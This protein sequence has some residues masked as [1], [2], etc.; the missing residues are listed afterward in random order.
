MDHKNGV[1]MVE[2]APEMPA[3][4]KVSRELVTLLKC[5]LADAEAGKIVAGGVVVVIGPSNFAAF[6]AMGVYPGEIIA[7][8]AVLTAD[9][10]T[11]MRQPRP[12]SI[13]QPGRRQ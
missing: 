8:A 6:G 9:T 11:K 5:A 12:G 3:S 7:G 2:L 10:I 4:V 1:A 13:I